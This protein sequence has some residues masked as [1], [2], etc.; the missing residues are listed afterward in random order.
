MEYLLVPHNSLHYMG[1]HR[2]I[3]LLQSFLLD[4]FQE[5]LVRHDFLLLANAVQVVLVLVGAPQEGLVPARDL[6]SDLHTL[7]RLIKLKVDRFGGRCQSKGVFN[8]RLI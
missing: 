6:G 5:D 1:W 4:S 2:Q 8:L 3:L 7:S